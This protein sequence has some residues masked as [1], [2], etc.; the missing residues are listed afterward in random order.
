MPRRVDPEV[1]YVDWEN[2]PTGLASVTIEPKPVMARYERPA[3]WDRA[4]LS[5]AVQRLAR[6]WQRKFGWD[7]VGG[8]VA[9]TV[10]DPSRRI[11]EV[12]VECYVGTFPNA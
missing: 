12:Y 9:E 11:T 4:N 8:I 7:L 5:I 3:A 10:Y 6:R 1:A 2:F